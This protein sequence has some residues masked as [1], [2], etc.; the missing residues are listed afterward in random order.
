MAVARAKKTTAVESANP[1]LKAWD[2]YV[3]EASHDPI[4]IPLP[5]GVRTVDF[6]TGGQLEEFNTAR[7]M[8]NEEGA[9]LA[10]FGKEVGAELMALARVAP[11]GAL[12]GLIQDALVAWG[13]AVPN[14]LTSSA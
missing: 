2:Q 4:D 14:S 10:L 3:T 6:P 7:Y 5:D 12:A 8:G 9:M 1:S 13:L 11:V